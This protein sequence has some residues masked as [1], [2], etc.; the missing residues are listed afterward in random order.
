V[1]PSSCVTIRAVVVV[2][3]GSAVA[4]AQPML[5]DGAG[6]PRS[7]ASAEAIVVVSSDAAFEAALDDALVPSGMDVIVIGEAG[8]PSSAELTSRSRALADRERAT[9]TVWLM[10]APSGAT[11]V[12]YD[13]RFDRLLVRELPYRS[14]LSATQAAEAARMVRTMLRVLRATDDN[15]D[16]DAGET[17]VAPLPAPPAQPVIAV[18]AGFGAWFFAPGRDRALVA[19][20]SL[21]WRPHGLGAALTAQ[22]A[23]AADV[24]AMTFAGE[25]RDIVVGA[26]VRRA[27]LVAPDLWIAPAAGLSLH[28]LEL[29]GSFGGAPV[30]SRRYDPAVRLGVT[31]RYALPHHVEVGVAVWADALLRRQSYEAASEQILLV[32]RLQ[33]VAGV[34]VGFWL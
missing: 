21:S 8:A 6:A 4:G 10:S 15:D 19:N 12:A 11:L 30:V 2:M 9:A 27:A 5:D 7:A 1:V 13:R 18:H 26:E 25:V 16:D 20:L 24:T 22:L 28:A 33:L 23:P 32:P 14:P 17:P 31:A 3:L 29:R 34:I